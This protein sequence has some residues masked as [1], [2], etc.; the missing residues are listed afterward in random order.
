MR[1]I[2]KN[3]FFAFI[4]NFCGVPIAAG[5]L[6]PTFGIMLS[7]TIASAAMALSSISVIGNALRLSNSAILRLRQSQRQPRPATQQI[8][9]SQAAAMRRGDALT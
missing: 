8:F 1:N 9:G 6:C 4:Y 3:L 5:V 2:R 7:P